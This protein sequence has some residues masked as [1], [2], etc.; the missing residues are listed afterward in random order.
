MKHEKHHH[1]IGEM[2][3]HKKREMHKAAHHAKKAAGYEKHP[4]THEHGMHK[5]KHSMKEGMEDNRHLNDTHQEGIARVLM[6]KGDMEVGQHGKMGEGHHSDAG[7]KR[8][9]GGGGLTPRKA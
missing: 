4:A 5:A 6:R 7:F 2:E 8:S 3:H 9:Q 1:R